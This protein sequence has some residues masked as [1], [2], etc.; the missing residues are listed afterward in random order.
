[1]PDDTREA[2]EGLFQLMDLSNESKRKRFQFCHA[3][4][5]VEVPTETDSTTHESVADT[6][7]EHA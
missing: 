2:I 1:M 4:V 6:G 3:E 5:P 7:E